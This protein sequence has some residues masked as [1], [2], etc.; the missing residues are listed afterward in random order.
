MIKFLQ[1]RVLETENLTT[2]R[3]DS[4]HYMFDGAV[5][6]GR[7]HRLEYQQHGETIRR[8]EQVLQL[9]QLVNTLLEPL[10]ELFFGLIVRLYLRR[11]FFQA[12]VLAIFYAE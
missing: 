1:A 2:L 9:A 3:I 10:F 6:A 7:V 11:P 4:G 5:L 12:D 8:I